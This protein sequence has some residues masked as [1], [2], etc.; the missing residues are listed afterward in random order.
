MK[1]KILLLLVLGS[2][3]RAVLSWVTL[4][5][6]SIALPIA[7]LAA[8][9]GA[10]TSVGVRTAP[11]EVPPQFENRFVILDGD[12]EVTIAS[13]RA[14]YKAGDTITIYI[15]YTNMSAD[16]LRIERPE[17][18]MHGFSVLPDTCKSSRQAGCDLALLHQIPFIVSPVLDWM[19][20]APGDCDSWTYPWNGRDRNGEQ[21][22]GRFTI[23]GGVWDHGPGLFLHDYILPGGGAPL[24]VAVGAMPVEMVPW[25]RVRALYR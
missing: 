16:T 6:V 8:A 12:V 21:L 3:A 24:G 7:A 2:G 1:S 13:E 25:G 14:E 20:L 11:C 22:L 5:A 19:V 9:A 15:F 18:P 10:E 4:L 17:S 23:L